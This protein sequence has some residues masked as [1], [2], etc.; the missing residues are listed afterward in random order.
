MTPEMLGFDVKVVW[1]GV[2]T[3][4][5]DVVQWFGQKM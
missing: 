1:D 5:L 4:L 2:V 3:A